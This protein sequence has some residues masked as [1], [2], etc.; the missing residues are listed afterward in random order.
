MRVFLSH[1]PDDQ[2][3]A[4]RIAEELSRAGFDVWSAAQ[5]VLPGDNW[6]RRVAEALESSEAMVVLLSPAAMRAPNVR[7]EIEYA[8]GSRHFEG[9][10]VP[11]VVRRTDDVPWILRTMKMLRAS[12]N[13]ADTGR[14]I[15]AHLRRSA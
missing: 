1:S 13:L 7:W 11:V 5:Q 10:L 2:P 14:E 8:L 4:D 12:R 15:A 6:A 3:T 9:R